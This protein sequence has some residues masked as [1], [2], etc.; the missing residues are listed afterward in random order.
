MARRGEIV[1]EVQAADELTDTQRRRLAEVLARVYHQP[2]SV[3]L[4]VDPE[5]LGGLS[6]AVGDEVIDGTLSSRL[7][8]A[9]TRLP[10]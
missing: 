7:A 4:N 6:V 1:A 10:D 9:A 3:Q 8:A 5:L 2:V